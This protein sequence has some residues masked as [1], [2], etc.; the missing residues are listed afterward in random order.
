MPLLGAIFFDLGGL[1]V[2][3]SWVL[4]WCTGRSP[5]TG[6]LSPGFRSQVI[7]DAQ[8][9]LVRRRTVN[10]QVPGSSPGRGARI[11]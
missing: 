6:G 9:V 11:Q 3:L 2:E 10:P 8:P 7:A 4:T 5:G 1:R